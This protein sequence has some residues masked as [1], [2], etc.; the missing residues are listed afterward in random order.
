MRR[1]Q[2][3]RTTWGAWLA[4]LPLCWL[5]LTLAAET[6]RLQL[7]WVPQAQFAGYYLAQDMGWYA[8]AGLQ[9]EILPDGSE[10]SPAPLLADG[11]ADIGVFN[12]AEAMQLLD[13]GH[14]VVNLQQFKR[15]SSLVLVSRRAT[16]LRTPEDLAGR[17]VARWDGFA[18][19]PDAL[20]RRNDVSPEIIEQGSSMALLSSVAVDVAMATGCN[21]MVGLY[22]DG[23]DLDELH[24]MPLADHG[25]GLP[26]DGVYVREADW[27]SRFEV[28]AEFVA[29]SRRGSTSPHVE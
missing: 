19:Q 18:I 13:A 14:A 15:E 26:E 21:E 12:L 1:H 10:H 20:F 23:M 8:A 16:G 22:L 17:R 2:P 25:V 4:L 6:L 24:I 3:R 29:I 9:L 28:F 5:P 7:Q 27:Q 11:T